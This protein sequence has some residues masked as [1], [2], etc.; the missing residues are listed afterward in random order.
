MLKRTKIIEIGP[1]FQKIV[2]NLTNCHFKAICLKQ[3]LH[4]QAVF[5]AEYRGMNT[6]I[7]F[8]SETG[9]NYSPILAYR[10]YRCNLRFKD[11]VDN[12]DIDA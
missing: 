7:F 11:L 9:I 8:N 12:H 4:F 1:I 3:I 6:L 2:Q 10:N 5:E